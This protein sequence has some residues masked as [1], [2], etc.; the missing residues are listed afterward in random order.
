[1]YRYFI[2][3]LIGGCAMSPSDLTERGQRADYTSARDARDV[4]ECLSR[5]AEEVK[6]GPYRE[7][8]PA[9][10]RTGRDP[11]TFEVLLQSAGGT[12]AFARVFPDA[13]GSRFTIWHDEFNAR[14]E[15]L[16]QQIAKGC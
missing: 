11:G 13:G 3:L 12:I 10:W 4:A 1:M 15:S 14:T 6:I 16:P 7:T 8:L 5:N 9:R 2:V